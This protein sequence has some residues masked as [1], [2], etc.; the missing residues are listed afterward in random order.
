MKIII[1]NAKNVKM[2]IRFIKIIL[3]FNKDIVMKTNTLIEFHKNVLTNA[4]MV[5]IYYFEL[6]YY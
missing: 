4:H 6:K 3:V 2:V 1:H 5:Q